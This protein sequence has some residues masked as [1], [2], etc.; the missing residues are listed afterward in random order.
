[1]KILHII[2]TPR[3]DKSNAHRVSN[4]FLESLAA[5][6]PDL[7]VDVLDLFNQDLPALAGDNI[8]AKYTLMLGQP[9][10]KDQAEQLTAC[11]MC[12][13]AGSYRHELTA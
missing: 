1:M 4:G 2:A 9:I 6:H 7:Q 13:K 8:E 10:S 11:Q 5:L 3:A 12:A